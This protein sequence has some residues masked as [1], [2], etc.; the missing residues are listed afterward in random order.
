VITLRNLPLL[1]LLVLVSCCCGSPVSTGAT[2]VIASTEEAAP[3]PSDPTTMR[4][5]VN[6]G[7]YPAVDAG[8]ERMKT[9]TRDL[10]ELGLVWLRHPGRGSAW[11]EVQPHRDRWDF[12]KLDAVMADNGHPWLFE[13]Y[14]QV[15]TVYPFHPDFS[16]REMRQKKGTREV[17]TYLRERSVDLQDEAQRAD[18]EAYTR[19]LVE[20]YGDRVTHW[21]IGNEGM[22]STNRFDLI[23][24]TYTWIKDVQPDAVVVLTGL[25]GDDERIYRQNIDALDQLLAQGAG[26]YFDVGNIHWYGKTGSSFEADLERRYTDY[27]DLLDRHGLRKPIWVTETSTSSSSSSVVSGPSSEAI[28]AR[29]VVIRLVVFAAMGADKVF[30]HGYR[31]TFAHNKFHE[32]NLRDSA[33]G[34]PKPGHATL[35]LLVDKIG[36]FESVETIRNDR[37]HL[38]RFTNPGGGRVL[39]GWTQSP[40]AMDLSEH[41]SGSRVNVTHI[42]EARG[43]EPRREQYDATAVQL[44]ESPVFVE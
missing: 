3:V 7:A 37:V 21:E 18:A 22:E 15:G 5:G 10:D 43:E 20:R 34:D 44:S 9:V 6:G 29:H 24:Y 41:V 23:Q 40:G 8:E 35:A 12:R 38:Y 19:K 30:W 28:Q 2:P 27:T 39:V 25:V 36:H 13:I 32:C 26:D 4:F 11:F 14:G 16:P 42:V 1:P 31:E 17:M 33:T